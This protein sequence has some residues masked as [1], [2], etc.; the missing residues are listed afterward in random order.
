M[1]QTLRRIY[2]GDN[3]RCT[4]KSRYFVRV[5]L[6]F[7]HRSHRLERLTFPNVK[8][9]FTGIDDTVWDFNLSFYRSLD[10]D[11]PTT[12]FIRTFRSLDLLYLSKKNECILVFDR[13]SPPVPETGTGESLGPWTLNTRRKKSR[14]LRNGKSV[15][16]PVTSTFRWKYTE[17]CIYFVFLRWAWHKL[18]CL[19]Y[20]SC[21]HTFGPLVGLYLSGEKSWDVLTFTYLYHRQSTTKSVCTF[22]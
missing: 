12:I 22:Y 18:S 4:K 17:T 6:F 15:S 7:W 19:E 11:Q 3:T 14:T 13:D 16:Y 20:R 2:L 1:F 21:L 8:P 9:T 10:T 5:S